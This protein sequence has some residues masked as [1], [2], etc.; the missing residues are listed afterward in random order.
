M[1]GLELIKH[2]G[3]GGPMTVSGT[4]VSVEK[5][6][7]IKFTDATEINVDDCF[8]GYYDN[9]LIVI[10]QT[11]SGTDYQELRLR[12]GS[13]NGS[14][15]THQRLDADDG[16]V[17][18]ARDSGTHS[19]GP[20]LSTMTSGYHIYLYGPHLK[21]PT[22]GRIVSAWGQSNA[23]IRDIAFTHSNN[24]DEFDGFSL[25]SSGGVVQATGSLT[26]YGFTKQNVV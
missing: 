13:N 7:K 19:R 18:G 11:G 10:R 23:Y 1:N 25:K 5:E 16:N 4:G 20:G 17:R 26:I 24:T 8:N 6:G 22:A 12:A 15:Y 2:S 9:Y 3:G 21:Q 14:G